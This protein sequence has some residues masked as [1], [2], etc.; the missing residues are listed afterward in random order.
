[1][2]DWILAI[3]S[4]VGFFLGIYVL[5][6]IFTAFFIVETETAVII[7]RFGKFHSKLEPGLH[8]MWPWIDRRRKFMWR[9]SESW[10]V[11]GRK[12]RHII[13]KKSSVI[14]LR[15]TV[16][17]LGI[18]S[19]ITRDNVSISVS[20]VIIYN[21]SDPVRALY[22]TSD[23]HAAV[24]KLVHTNIR[25]V[26][27]GLNLEDAFASRAEVN[28]LL[29]QKVSRICKCWGITIDKIEL[30][31]INPSHDVVNAM[32]LQLSSERTRRAQVI[33][34]QGHR[35]KDK[36][37]AEGRSQAG[38]TISQAES[39]AAKLRG[40]ATATAKTTM[41]EA[42]V[43]QLRKLSEALN[44]LADPAQYV[45]SW[46]MIEALHHIALNSDTVDMILPIEQNLGAV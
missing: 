6:F 38:I 22:E 20:G 27:G 39:I 45:L 16:L 15:Q 41:V 37:E 4:V 23:L 11:R 34:A 33:I 10:T 7:E 18:L 8:F 44:G 5:T 36:L 14:D 29:L 40:V 28:R 2:S 24:E 3:L 42:E 12:R 32:H 35:Q 1:M 19:V 9:H 21:I 43:E 25:S 46:M 30:L 13:Q 31:E 17:D 26:I